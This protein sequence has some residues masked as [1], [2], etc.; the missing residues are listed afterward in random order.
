MAAGSERGGFGGAPGR[1]LEGLLCCPE[2]RLPLREAPAGLVKALE[3]ERFAGGL[4]EAS[5]AAVMDE[6]T[7]GWL[8]SDGVVFYRVSRGVACLLPAQAIKVSE[9]LRA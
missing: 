6:I 5:G 9:G 1:V 4:R 2:T 7:A 3:Q 8:R